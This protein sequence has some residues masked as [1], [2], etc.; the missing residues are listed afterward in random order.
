MWAVKPGKCLFH[1]SSQRLWSKAFDPIGS[2]ATSSSITKSDLTWS[3]ISPQ[4]PPSTRIFLSVGK[5]KDVCLQSGSAS[6]ESSLPAFPTVRLRMKPLWLCRLPYLTLCA[7]NAP[8]VGHS[9]ASVC[10][11][12]SWWSSLWN[13]RYG[14]P[15][16]NL[17]KYLYTDCHFGKSLGNI[18][19][20]Q[21]LIKRYRIAWNV[22]RRWYLRCL[23]S[24]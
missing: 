1:D 16:S 2:L 4:Y 9:S 23:Q 3:A 19:H 17:R 20:W 11:W 7:S 13:A 18:L 8:T 24:F 6:L 22:E 21:P 12:F 5:K 14:S 15:T 10:V